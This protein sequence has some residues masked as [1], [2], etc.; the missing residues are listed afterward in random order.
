MSSVE[1]LM[2]EADIKKVLYRYCRAVDR[3]DLPLLRTVY[4]P[5]AIDDHGVYVGPVEGFFDFIAAGPERGFVMTQHCLTNILV[6]V[7]GDVAHSESY[8]FSYH[9]R[10][11]DSGMFEET[12]GGRYVDRLERRAGEWRISLRKVVMDWSRILPLPNEFW[13]DSGN[14][15]TTQLYLTQAGTFTLGVRGSD[16]PSY[17]YLKA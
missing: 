2:D 4:H 15:S 8:F 10:R 11:T 6:D 13:A 9:R 14:L 3:L 5:D 1:Q 17:A 12:S 7:D 16:D